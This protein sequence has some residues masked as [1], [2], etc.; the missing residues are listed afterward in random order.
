MNDRLQ[1][2]RLFA[3]VARLG[4][5]SRAGKEL[6]LSQPSASRIVANL[7][8]EVGAK[9]LTRTTRAVT[10]TEAGAD[11]L[12]HI[13]PILAALE[14]ADHAARGTGELKG[15]LRIGVGTSFG[16]REIVPRL[17]AFL[18]RHP[19]LRV[20]LAI[21]DARQDLLREGVDLAL[22]FGSAADSSLVVRRLGRTTLALFA[23]PR[24]LRTRGAPRTPSDLAGHTLIL[25]PGS[26]SRREWSFAKD[27]HR[28]SIVPPR[29][30]VAAS[31]N[32][33]VT[34][35][36]VES[37]G[38][39]SMTFWGC[40]AELER[41]DLVRV[42]A[43]WTMDSVDLFAVFPAGAAKPAARAFADYLATDAA[44]LKA[45]PAGDEQ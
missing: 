22:R 21:D 31:A 41:G 4:A 42:M 12:A 23:S 37:L 34:A 17:P 45:P 35:A 9:L 40:R 39:A 18:E 38:V 28:E 8:R 20:D 27:D 26:R 32:E 5:F 1:A 33:A 11:Y 30:R 36:A 3:R 13:E 15:L 16:I 10:T 29:W 44:L 19:S 7:E 24:Y 43:D 25:G 2:L 6:G 14:E